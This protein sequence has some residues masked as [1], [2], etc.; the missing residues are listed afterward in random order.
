MPLPTAKTQIVS[1]FELLV[2]LVYGP[3][4]IGKSSFLADFD[5]PLFLTTER[6]H[7]HL[8]IYERKIENWSDF[9]VAVTE[10][11]GPNGKRFKTVGIDTLPL[12]YGMCLDYVCEKKGMEHPS[13]EDFGRG[14]DFVNQEFQRE[15]VRLSLL[16][17]GIVFIAHHKQ[18]EVKARGLKYTKTAPKLPGG[19]W[20]VVGPMVDII[21]YA[22]FDIND[23]A[24]RVLIT[25]PRE[26]L[27]AGFRSPRALKNPLPATLPLSY[28]A[29]KEA[30]AK[31]DQ[32]VPASAGPR[33]VVAPA[34]GPRRIVSNK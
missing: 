13:D 28:K 1:D 3:P 2:W 25:Q 19:C 14:Y 9:K 11:K 16:G 22:G 6:G 10:L 31:R 23:M 4:K 15:M 29:V 26:D 5:D 12:L 7:R 27:E 21:A 18:V 30:W 32:I 24:K 8:S 17:K 33:K 34:A 20:G